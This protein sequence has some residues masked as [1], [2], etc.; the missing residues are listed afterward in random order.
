[1]GQDE[2]TGAR[3]VRVDGGS[4]VAAMTAERYDELLNLPHSHS[5]VE[6]LNF[7]IDS[8]SNISLCW[9]YDIFSYVKPCD[10]ES[11]TPLGSTPLKVNGVGVMRLCLGFYVDHPGERYPLDIEIPNVYYVP[12]SSLNILSATHIKRYNMFLNTQFTPDLLI[13]P[14]LLSQVTGTWGDWHQTYG[15][16]GYPAIYVT[17]GRNN[18]LCVCTLL[19]VVPHGHLLRRLLIKSVSHLRGTM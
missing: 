8:G 11:Y 19:T 1:M 7:S 15:Q 13:I 2:G 17:L 16:V 5:L 10:L 14:G 9:N 12:E 18:V 4:A 3:L 6:P